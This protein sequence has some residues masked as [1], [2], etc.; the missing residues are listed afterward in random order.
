VQPPLSF[1]IHMDLS[2]NVA[3]VG[4]ALGKLFQV[5]DQDFVSLE[6]NYLE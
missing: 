3:F 4:N 6:V 1:Q 5:L 2:L